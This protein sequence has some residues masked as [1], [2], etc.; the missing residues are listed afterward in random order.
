MFMEQILGSKLR[1]K[2][3]RVFFEYPHREFSEGEIITEACVGWGMA[4]ET[5]KELAGFSLLVHAKKGKT[6]YFKLNQ[7]S[8]YF[9]QISEL[10]K[11]E[12]SLTFP[13]SSFVYRSILSDVLEATLEL[14]SFVSL[15]VFGSVASGKTTPLSDIDVVLILCDKDEE[16][17]KIAKKV[18]EI[19]RKHGRIVSLHCFTPDEMKAE[20]DLMK[21]I[22]KEH[23]LICGKKLDEI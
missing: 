11:V 18:S 21:S 10:F 22:K 9:S 19:S 16:E 2:L 7:S 20:S 12:L 6:N 4:H 17:A 13:S 3:L 14:K 1:V 5:L 23:I 15:A 8:K